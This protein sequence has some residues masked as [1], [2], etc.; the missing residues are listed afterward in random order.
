MEVEGKLFLGYWNIRGIGE[1]ARLLLEY[2]GLPYEDHRYDINAKPNLWFTQDKPK[3][4][5]KTPAANLPYI[6]DG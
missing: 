4:L 3:L 5:E 1:R 2:V 6:R